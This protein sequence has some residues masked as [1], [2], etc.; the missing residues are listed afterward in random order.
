L[1]LG[2]GKGGAQKVSEYRSF[3]AMI[4]I[5]LF[6]ELAFMAPSLI[7]RIPRIRGRRRKKQQPIRRCGEGRV[8]GD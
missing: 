4:M 2:I 8:S 5:F 7:G 6:I 3:K 1:D